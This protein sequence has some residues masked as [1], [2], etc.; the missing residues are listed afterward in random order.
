M[1][2][3][4]INT[5]RCFIL[6]CITDQRSAT[7]IGDAVNKYHRQNC[8]GTQGFD[9][10]MRTVD[11]EGFLV[12]HQLKFSS[13]LAL[14][15]RVHTQYAALSTPLL[16]YDPLKSDFIAFKIN[17]I[18]IRKHCCQRR[19]EYAPTCYYICGHRIFMT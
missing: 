4:C 17:T 5:I 7:Q 15:F 8:P 1:T 13:I 19:Y 6:H 16:S 18:S 9:E 11:F 12:H 2:P 14:N 3:F 10:V